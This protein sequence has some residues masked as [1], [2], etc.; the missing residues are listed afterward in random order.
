[1][2]KLQPWIYS[3]KLDGLFILSPPFVSLLVVFLLPGLFRAGEGIPVFWWIV[4]IVCID[5]AH[6]YSTLYR[7]YFDRDTFQ[8][9]KNILIGIPVV[10]FVVA[11]ILYS[12]DDMVFWRVLAYLAVFHFVRQQYGFMRIYSRKE[13]FNKWYYRVDQTAIYM[14]T[15][16]P[17]LYWHLNAPRNFNWFVEGD[18][19]YF[20]AEW[21]L[22]IATILYL[23]VIAAYLV[24]EVVFIVK[25]K[26]VN[27]PR[28]LVMAGT[29]LSWYFGIV[30]YNGDMAFTL[31]NVV[32][33]G[34]PYM[35]LIWV[36]GKKKTEAGTSSNYGK[37]ISRFFTRYGIVLFLL[38]MI[39]MAYVEEGFW[40]AWIWKEHKSA[41]S[42]FYTFS[43][44]PPKEVLALLV[45]LLALPQ[46][47]HYIIDGYIWKVSR[48]HIPFKRS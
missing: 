37:L 28:N 16:F 8:Q 9:Q 29:F 27:V 11:V 46:I 48:G 21:L 15:V 38:S 24:K 41:F 39:V 45:P 2:K 18:F 34:V 35:A 36:Y 30:Y 22:V 13:L 42:I 6:V 10:G 44:Q 4:L 47:T 14:A 1:M 19:V 3:M 12:I 33:H 25:E 7:T 5:V 23:L 17:I 32:S 31:L 40:D 43:F 26:Q 20:R